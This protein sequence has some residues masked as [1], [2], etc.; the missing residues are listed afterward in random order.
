MKT[1]LYQPRIEPLF[2]GLGGGF[3]S[4]TVALNGIALHR[5]RGGSGI[6][7]VPRI[8]AGLVRTSSIP[9]L[10]RPVLKDFYPVRGS[11]RVVRRKAP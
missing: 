2:A 4:G 7:P 11:A 10:R 3:Q 8:R 1:A 9:A 6:P 5:A